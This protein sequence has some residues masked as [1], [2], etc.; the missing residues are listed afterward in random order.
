MNGKE[1][2]KR[3]WTWNF[4][5]LLYGGKMT[6]EFRQ[7]PGVI[8]VKDCLAWAKFTMA[9][10][11]AAIKTA[12]SYRSL[13]VY[14]EGVGGLKSFVRDGVEGDSDPALLDRITGNMK[15][16]QRVDSQ[17]IVI[18]GQDRQERLEEKMKEDEVR[19]IKF[20]KF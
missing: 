3:Y 1:A 17:T 14:E 15:E 9:F 20:A 11:G 13:S 8:A 10:C 7:P 16:V 4:E 12:D 5:N 19:K 18:L 6:T 2:K